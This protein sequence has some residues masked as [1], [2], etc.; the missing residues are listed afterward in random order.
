MTETTTPFD[1]D[2]QSLAD[3]NITSPDGYQF[4][5]Y[6]HAH[7]TYLR[8]HAPAFR[9]QAN[10]EDLEPFWAITKWE[11]IQNISRNP[12]VFSSQVE[13]IL[14]LDQAQQA[15]ATP[16]THHLLDMD[17]PEHS[18]YRALVNR[19]FTT[20]GLRLLE[21]RIDEVADEVVDRAA[22]KI[23]DEVAKR[24]ECE[25]VAD[26]SNL[27]PLATICELLGVPREREGDVIQ[28]VNEMVGAGDPDYQRG[29]TLEETLAQ[30]TQ[31]LLGF[32]MQLTQQK[33]QQPT[34]D[35]LTTLVQSEINGAPLGPL[36]LLS[37]C[38]LLIIAGNET[39]RNTTTGG[40]LALIQHPEQ[41][42][43]LRSDRSLMDSAIEEILRWV[44][45][46]IHF[47]RLVTEDVE[48]GG[49]LIPAGDKVVLFY[50][51]ANRDEDVFENPF[52]FDITR[53]P[54]EHLAFG[55]FGE[56]YCIGA[57]LARMQLRTIFSKM[58]DRMDEIELNG[59]Y[60][61]LRSGFVGGIKR[62]PIAY[63]AT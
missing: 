41:M 12:Q 50:P 61:R 55:G 56:H 48:V 54:N 43:L 47:V 46:V 33:R 25:A 7:W 27:L 31:S 30:A 60:E 40:L 36:D 14:R 29:R 62:M 57:N 35:L 37:Y 39:T 9:Y 28:W 10:D 38:Y 13:S 17:P 26:I 15:G 63:V 18:Q 32:F 16:Q 58:L 2:P 24:G 19:R 49:Q 44:S 8:E 51:S 20:R 52:E 3:V 34:D 53:T 11:D 45:P 4:S 59:D 23:V 6:P 5:G 1:I 21:G 22:S 42:A